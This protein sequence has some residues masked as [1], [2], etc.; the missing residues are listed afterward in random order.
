M[1]IN[2]QFDWMPRHVTIQEAW[3]PD[4]WAYEAAI[5]LSN[6]PVFQ[7]VN[8]NYEEML[9]SEGDTVNVSI[10][11]TFKAKRKSGDDIT[12]QD[13][14]AS[15]VP[16]VL[17]QH[18]HVSFPIKDVDASKAF[19]DLVRIY[20]T[21]ALTAIS[22]GIAQII[23]GAGMQFLTNTVGSISGNTSIESVVIDANKKAMDL[24]IPTGA[25]NMLI[26][27]TTKAHL[28]NV[29]T[30]KDAN[31]SGDNGIT[32]R[33]G[34]VQDRYD[35]NFVPTTYVPGIENKYL[36]RATA[37]TSAA[38]D[39]GSAVLNFATDQSAVFLIG[40]YV[41]IPGQEGIFRVLAASTDGSSSS[42]SSSSSA[43]A[44]S[45]SS[46]AGYTVTLDRVVSPAVDL[47]TVVTVY[48]RAA[49]KLVDGYLAN[50]GGIVATDGWDDNFPPTPGM[51]VRIG[52]YVYVIMEATKT[53]TGEYDLVFTEPLYAAISNNDVIYVLPGGQYNPMWVPQA[54]TFVS[55][56]LLSVSD[57]GVRSAVAATEDISVR[58]TISYD[59]IK[60]RRIVTIDLLCGIKVMRQQ[61]GMILL[62]R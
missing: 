9:Q 18:L 32:N 35:F 1:K 56:P 62:D 28:L 23:T 13:T 22:E 33:T 47:G 15:S 43:S 42:S 44:S 48:D 20:L 12:I 37:T 59:A 45:S 29:Q 50:W 6:L 55:R 38:T 34:I 7:T 46:A 41:A 58:A 19:V 51:P 60:Q 11:G 21:P 14:S 24:K 10:P 26:G 36:K 4:L 27:S 52:S 16:V 17:N 30:F 31:K 49:V 40:N 61:M 54:V 25:R 5:V 53:D 3:T 39:E 57:S 2:S 8:R